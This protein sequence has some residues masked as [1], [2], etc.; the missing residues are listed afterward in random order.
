MRSRCGRGGYIAGMH[1]KAFDHVAVWAAERDA[2]ARVL[3][4][5]CGM[6]EIERTQT[7][8]LVGGDARRGKLTLFDA[9]GP[10]DS[11]AL[12]RVVVR[13][14][15]LAES[16]RCLEASKV[17]AGEGH[18]GAVSVAAP[19]QL[20]LALV[21][22]HGVA[23]LDHVVLRVGDPPAAAAALES[24]GLERSGDEVHVLDKRL[25]LRSGGARETDRPLLNHL[26]FLVDAAAEIEAEA[27]ERGLE[28]DDVVDAANTRAVFIWGPERIRLEYVEHKPGFS[29]A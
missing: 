6:H 16:R 25:V 1:A 28:I 13:V 21:Q 2:L 19:S 14:P 9:D 3:T 18:D 24:M 15:D 29:L 5:C 20:P 27:R 23:D 4:A 17:A 26:A 8:T 12:E 10:R 11:G 22:G 7:F